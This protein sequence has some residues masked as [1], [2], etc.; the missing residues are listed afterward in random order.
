MN[1][2]L[3]QDWL[4]SIWI[5]IRNHPF[6]ENTFFTGCRVIDTH[7]P[8]LGVGM[9]TL[10]PDAKVFTVNVTYIVNNDPEVYSYTS[11]GAYWMGFEKSLK[12][13]R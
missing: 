12:R 6:G 3:L 13:Y 9:V 2:T 11:D 10:S 4:Y 7:R 8:E 5:A 1:I